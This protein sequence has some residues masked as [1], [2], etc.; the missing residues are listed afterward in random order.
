MSL[1]PVGVFSDTGT[2]FILFIT[3]VSVLHVWGGRREGKAGE[4]V[5]SSWPPPKS[6]FLNIFY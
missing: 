1:G 2:M 4:A 6:F 5:A 3:L